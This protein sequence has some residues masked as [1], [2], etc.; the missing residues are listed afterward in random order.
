MKRL[1]TRTRTPGRAH[2]LVSMLILSVAASLPLHAANASTDQASPPTRANETAGEKAADKARYSTGTPAPPRAETAGPLYVLPKVGKPRDRVG[3]GRR[4]PGAATAEIRALVPSHVAHTRAEQPVLYWSLSSNA[5]TDVRFELTL[6]DQHSIDPVV[7]VTL[8]PPSHAGLQ[9][10]A[11]ADYGVRLALGE[12]YEWS[13]A[14]VPDASRRSRDVLDRGFIE[15][16]P[17]PPAVEQA[18]RQ[19]G[20]RLDPTEEV[21]LYAASGLWYDALDAAYREY[22]QDPQAPG[23]RAHFDRLLQDASLPRPADL[24]VAAPPV[25]R[26]VLMP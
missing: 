15:R 17:S 22:Q 20:P 24:P 23:A 12:E 1:D 19:A 9:R 3:G 25:P 2:G 8:A 10:V 4:L 16:V 21:R 26:P 13:V 14:L 6:I 5:S 18:L 7:E 11:L